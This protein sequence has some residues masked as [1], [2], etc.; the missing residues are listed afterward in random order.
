MAVAHMVTLDRAGNMCFPGISGRSKS[1]LTVHFI[2]RTMCDWGK[3]IIRDSIL[4]LPIYEMGHENALHMIDYTE[5][6]K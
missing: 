1:T 3:S 5:M 4:Y 6:K 2:S